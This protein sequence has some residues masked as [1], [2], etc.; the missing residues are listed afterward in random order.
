MA[1]RSTPTRAETT[2]SAAR[3]AR[4]EVVRTDLSENEIGHEGCDDGNPSNLDACLNIAKSRAAATASSAFRPR[5]GRE[6]LDH[7]D[8]GNRIEE[9]AYAIS[10]S[11]RSAAMAS[12][13]KIPTLKA[14]ASSSVT[15]ATT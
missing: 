15:T 3:C 10:A 2:A 1:T 7:R 14:N 4:D 6:R 13:A 11:C 5:R 9:D 12:F 8:D